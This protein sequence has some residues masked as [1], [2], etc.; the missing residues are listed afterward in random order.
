MT[1]PELNSLWVLVLNRSY[2]PLQICSGRRAITMILGGRA[3]AVEGD[4]FLV[5]SFHLSLRLPSVIRLQRYVRIPR[6]GEIAFSKRNVFRRDNHSCQY[7]GYQGKGLTIDHVIPRSRG[8]RTSWENVV[9]AC[10]PCNSEKGNRTLGESGFSLLRTPHRPYFLFHH[11][12][13]SSIQMST[14]ET[15]KKYI[16]PFRP[17]RA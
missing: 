7:C 2:E 10:Q 6:R 16:E 8:G 14:L 3:E 13:A 9:V 4:G 5:R 1:T 11:Y 12:V 15:W 17:R